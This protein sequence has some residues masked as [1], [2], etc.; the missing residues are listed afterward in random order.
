LR[1]RALTNEQPLRPRCSKDGPGRAKPTEPLLGAERDH[2]IDPHRASGRQV[3]RNQRPPTSK[4]VTLKKVT[5]SSPL[6]LPS[7]RQAASRSDR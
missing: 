6:T 5:G 7:T 3:D 2:R 1:I 4:T